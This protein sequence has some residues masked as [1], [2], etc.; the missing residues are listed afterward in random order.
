MTGLVIVLLLILSYMTY[1]RFRCRCKPFLPT[2]L[3]FLSKMRIPYMRSSQ[4][5]LL[6]NSQEISEQSLTSQLY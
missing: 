5:L 2:P 1:E 3:P 6:P 4:Q